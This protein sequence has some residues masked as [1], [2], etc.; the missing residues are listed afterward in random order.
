MSENKSLAVDLIRLDGGTQSRVSINQE[1]V[2]EY[3]ELIS[4]SNGQWPFPPIDVFHD[5]SDYFDADGFHRVLAALNAKRGSIPCRV[6]KGTARDARI[7]GMTANDKHGM[8]MT[9]ADKRSSVEWLLDIY[10]TMTQKEIAEKAGVTDRTVRN[11]IAERKQAKQPAI[12]HPKGGRKISGPP[13]HSSGKPSP[14]L[15]DDPFADPPDVKPIPADR[16]KCPNCAGTKWTEDD[17]GVAC[18]KCHHPHGEPAGDVDEKQITIQRSK[19][20]KTA[21]A[22]MRAFDDLNQLRPKTS[23]YTRSIDDCKRL[24]KIAKGWK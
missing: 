24:V 2:D 8:R 9:R 6:H 17:D 3:A 4:S 22:L 7:F 19:T 12:E 23:E 16:G 14:T 10:G 21:E 5:G 20:V 18:S 1:V 11:I 13:T 15:E